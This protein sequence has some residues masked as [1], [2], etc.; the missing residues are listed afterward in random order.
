[1]ELLLNMRN[2]E[3]K[4]FN[5]TDSKEHQIKIDGWFFSSPEHKVLMVSYCGQWLSVVVR[6]HL[7]L[8]F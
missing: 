2:V 4:T 7:M 3:Y 6:Q 8:T 1:M 5:V